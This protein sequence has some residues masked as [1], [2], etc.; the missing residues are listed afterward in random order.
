VRLFPLGLSPLRFASYCGTD[1]RSCS[2]PPNY[3]SPTLPS[4]GFN[5]WASTIWGWITQASGGPGLLPA[6]WENSGIFPQILLHT[7]VISI[8]FSTT[9][10]LWD[11]APSVCFSGGSA[12]DLLLCTPHLRAFKIH[13]F[14]LAGL[15]HHIVSTV[16]LQSQI[17]TWNLTR[18]TVG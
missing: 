5:P 15:G 3:L 13:S 11:R 4:P 16:I 6:T 8:A 18:M 1:N 2:P 17:Q 10:A 9:F 7:G 14:A 12:P